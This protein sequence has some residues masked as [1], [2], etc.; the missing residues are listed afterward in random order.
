L[1]A[2]VQQRFGRSDRSAQRHPWL[3]RSITQTRCAKSKG[4]VWARPPACRARPRC[5]PA[6]PGRS[7]VPTWV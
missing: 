5:R 2:S 7:G 6:T 1:R 3:L 4:V